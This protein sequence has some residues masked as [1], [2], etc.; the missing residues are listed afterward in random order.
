MFIVT[1]G[2]NMY[3]L[4]G[5]IHMIVKISLKYDKIICHVQ[6]VIKLQL[7]NIEPEAVSAGHT[8]SVIR[9]PILISVLIYECQIYIIIIV[10]RNQQLCPDRTDHSCT[11]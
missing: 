6:S 4:F 8:D 10:T 3:D 1:A 7:P 9:I 2:T 5:R 11:H